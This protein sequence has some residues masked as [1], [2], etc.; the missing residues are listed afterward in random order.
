MLFTSYLNGRNLNLLYR[1]YL[2]FCLVSVIITLVSMAMFYEL[3]P[4]A[5]AIILWFKIITMGVF[6]W[7]V[8]SYKHKEFYY[9]RNLGL[10]K[11]KLFAC[12]LGFDFVVFVLL[13]VLTNVVR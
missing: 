1:F 9:Y 6:S 5:A 8:S 12:T 2:N 7:Y 13:M 10:S 3:G 11:F 4:G